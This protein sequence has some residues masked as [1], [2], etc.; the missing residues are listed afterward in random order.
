M[1]I[2]RLDF[3]HYCRIGRRVFYLIKLTFRVFLQCISIIGLNTYL[4][5][6]FAMYLMVIRHSWLLISHVLHRARYHTL[7]IMVREAL[8]VFIWGYIIEIPWPMHLIIKACV[9]GLQVNSP[10]GRKEWHRRCLLKR[11]EVISE[12]WWR[13]FVKWTKAVN[14]RSVGVEYN[15]CRCLMFV[16]KV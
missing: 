7:E 9:Q 3:I 14:V 11:I 16:S 8:E 5:Y 1:F 12:R 2:D 4:Q 13:C 6:L 15:K 10:S